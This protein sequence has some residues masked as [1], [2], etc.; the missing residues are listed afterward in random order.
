MGVLFFIGVQIVGVIWVSWM[1]KEGIADY[2][3]L[4]MLALFLFGTWVAY[5]INEGWIRRCLIFGVPLPAPILS[6]GP[7]FGP[8][9]VDPVPM[10]V[11]IA[12]AAIGSVLV[13]GVTLAMVVP[14]FK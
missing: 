10:G 4:A 2:V 11:R 7:L 1:G 13:L 8:L 3:G 12:C 9:F 5:R 6:C 14:A